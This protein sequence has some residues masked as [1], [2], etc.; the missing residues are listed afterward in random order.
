ML[1]PFFNDLMNKIKDILSEL[2]FFVA[3]FIG[4]LLNSTIGLHSQQELYLSTFQAQHPE[5]EPLV[6]Y[7]RNL[8][9]DQHNAEVIVAISLAILSFVFAYS[10]LRSK[11]FRLAIILLAVFFNL[12]IPLVSKML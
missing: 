3:L 4:Y 1:N 8:F 6:F 9:H 11:V 5:S 12:V 2:V 7:V 10:N